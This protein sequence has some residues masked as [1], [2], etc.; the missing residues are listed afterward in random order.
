MVISLGSALAGDWDDVR[1]DIRAVREA[2]SG[3]VLK[4]IIEAAALDDAQKERASE[5][6]VSAGADFVKTNTGFGGGGATLADVDFN[7][8]VVVGR[9]EIKASGGTRTPAEA[10]ALIRAGATRLGTSGGVGLVAGARSAA[11]Y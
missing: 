8:R 3:R 2:T 7:P 9:A 5:A 1:A 10:E 6:A 4:V 11:E